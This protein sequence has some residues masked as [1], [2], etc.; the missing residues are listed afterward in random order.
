[1]DFLKNIGINENH[2]ENHENHNEN[3]NENHPKTS[4]V[5]MAGGA[6]V[7]L[8]LGDIILEVEGQKMNKLEDYYLAVGDCVVG[9]RINFKVLRD[10]KELNKSLEL[11]PRPRR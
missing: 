11:K 2:N 5:E 3:H 7:N 8:K 9:Q 6:K 10:G 1:M 4:V